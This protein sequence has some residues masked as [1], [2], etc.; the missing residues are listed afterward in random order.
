[1]EMLRDFRDYCV[2][3]PL[4]VLAVYLVFAAL[5]GMWSFH[6]MVT[7]DAEGFFSFENGAKWYEQW[8]VLGRWGFVGLK[9]V[10]RVVAI[11]PYF[12]TAFFLLLF[13][14]SALVWGFAF[15]RWMD[16][17]RR[18]WACVLFCALFLSHPIWALQFAYRNQM[19]VMSVALVLAPVGMLMLG[20]FLDGRGRS[21]GIGAFAIAT[22]LFGCYQS[23]IFVY[24]EAACILLFLRVRAGKTERPW[25]ELIA[26]VGIVVA[27]F[28][29]CTLIGKAV[30]LIAGVPNENSYLTNQFMWGKRPFLENVKQILVYIK[31]SAFGDGV[32]YGA[33]FAVEGIALVGI[34]VAMA[35]KGQARLGFVALM[36]FGI[37]ASPFVLE[38]VTAGD[39]VIRSQ[40]AFVLALAFLGAFEIDLLAGVLLPRSKGVVPVL[41]VS[42]VA[43]A[44]VVF[45]AQQQ[46]RLL[47][48]D[49]QTMD[50]DRE[51]MTQIYYQAMAQGARPGDALCLVGPLPTRETD[52]LTE[53]EVIGFS[54]FEVSSFYGPNKTVEAMQAY[55][56]DVSFPTQE[57]LEAASAEYESL[58]AWPHAGAIKVHDGFYVVRLW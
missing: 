4:R 56:F 16:D 34:F 6:H 8:I 41:V 29:L 46:S 36:L 2:R 53:S 55:G 35:R 3:K 50:K 26:C 20:E 43:L 42:A 22:F 39:V 19:E 24:V 13:P 14:L 49:V 10:L 9:H 32:Q 58:E 23:F 12:S 28:V 27:A 38:V 31:H 33:T 5:F 51:T 57:Q 45:Q 15:E 44:A 17:E 52:D 37:L 7:F 25:R 48:T 40:F 18:A 1:M 21:F 30:L 54:Y 47:Y 11:N